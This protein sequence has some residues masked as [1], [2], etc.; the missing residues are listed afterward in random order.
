VDDFGAAVS[1]AKQLMNNSLNL[2][3]RAVITDLRTR[4]KR[5]RGRTKQREGLKKVFR[6][7]QAIRK[8]T[9]WRG[10]KRCGYEGLKKKTPDQG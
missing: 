5:V 8:S 4:K 7:K 1:A 2:P 3:T 6:K 10:K 9:N